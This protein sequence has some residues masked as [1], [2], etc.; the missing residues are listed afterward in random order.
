LNAL[1]PMEVRTLVA[2]VVDLADDFGFA[3]AVAVVDDAGAL[4]VA[5]RPGTVPAGHLDAALAAA[6]AALGDGGEVQAF[7]A[8]G[9]RA[10]AVAL[11]N[12]ALRGALAVSGGPDGFA[13]EACREAARALGLRR[14]A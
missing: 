3:C 8:A 1:T 12:G 6:R 7:A 13:L 10:S 9:G 14:A 2:V 4:R 11:G 5:E